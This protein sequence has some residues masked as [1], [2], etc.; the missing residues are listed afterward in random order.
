[1][2]RLTTGLNLTADQQKQAREIFRQ[3]RTEMNALT[4]KLRE[5]TAAMAGAVKSDSLQKIDQV[6]QQEAQLH[7]QM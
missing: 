2:D 4:P 3:S 1:M 5:D 7:A 6:A